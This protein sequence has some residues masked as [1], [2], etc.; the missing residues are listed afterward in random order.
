MVSDWTGLY[1]ASLRS[2][3][4]SNFI[5]YHYHIFNKE[6]S[7]FIAEIKL[8]F[9]RSLDGFISSK[10]INSCSQNYFAKDDDNSDEEFSLSKPTVMTTH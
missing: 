5:V 4:I 3:K 2:V 10:E 7:E 1:A 6:L 8:V 9:L